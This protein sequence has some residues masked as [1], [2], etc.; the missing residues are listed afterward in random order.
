MTYSPIR[1]PE[2]NIEYLGYLE[3]GDWQEPALDL[4]ALVE[5]SHQVL[6]EHG[7]GNGL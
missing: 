6:K 5:E 3:K 4:K 2:G 1:G 7:E